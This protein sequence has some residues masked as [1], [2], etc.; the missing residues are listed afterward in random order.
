MDQ[1]SAELLEIFMPLF[2]E[3]ENANTSLSME[4]FCTA[5]TKLYHVSIY[6]SVFLTI[7]ILFSWIDVGSNREAG[8]FE[9]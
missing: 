7:R 3:L 2:I 9:L 8:D 4:E 5:A 6:P 1:V